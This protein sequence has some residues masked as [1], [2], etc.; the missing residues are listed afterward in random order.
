MD[1]I[2]DEEVK[3][4]G[5]RQGGAP[6]HKERG[7]FGKIDR[8][9]G[10]GF[11]TELGR[12]SEDESGKTIHY[13]LI[14][15]GMTHEQLHHIVNDGTP[16]AEH[17]RAAYDHALKRIKDGKSPFAEEGEQ[18]DLPAPSGD[19]EMQEGFEQP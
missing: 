6:G 3:T 1:E 7:Y 17:E 13:P 15:P 5:M 14:H 16:T 18:G 12:S 9:D 4:W 2:T 11:S 8:K 19:A 10:K